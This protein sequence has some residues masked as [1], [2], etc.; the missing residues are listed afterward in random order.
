LMM[1][2]GA[3]GLTCRRSLLLQEESD[4]ELTCRRSNACFFVKLCFL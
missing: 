3:H 1:S 4:M 2:L